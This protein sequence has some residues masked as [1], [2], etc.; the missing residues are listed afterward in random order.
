MMT[1]RKRIAGM[2]ETAEGY[3]AMRC[4]HNDR[5]WDVMDPAGEMSEPFPTLADAK[6]YAE[7]DAARRA[8]R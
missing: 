8:A 6:A 7:R 5:E 2:Y 3:A 1:W 4:E